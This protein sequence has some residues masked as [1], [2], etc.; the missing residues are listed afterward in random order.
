MSRNQAMLL[1]AIATAVSAA[2]LLLATPG[3]VWLRVAVGIP[4]VLL[5]PGQALMLFVD[6]DGQLG[7]LE[8]FTL[9]V[10]A[11]I[12]LAI[13]IGMGLATSLGLTASGMIQT[14]T[15]FTVL[16]L[17]AARAHADFVPPR[18]LTVAKRNP[19]R[20]AALGALALLACAA[21]VLALSI[22]DTRTA[23]AD[24]TVQLWGLPDKSGGGLRIGA[25]NV[26][27]TSRR[28]RLT[29]Q[30]GGRLISQQEFTMPAGTDRQFTVLKSATWTNSA[31][32]VAVLTDMN[33][34]LSPRNIS[35]WTFE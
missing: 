25:N 26:N 10:S 19:A 14:L 6:P 30:Q 12:A 13:L 1:V 29:I 21:F 28:Y 16:C 15:F 31:P 27:A 9:S 8:W 5:L 23:Q 7:G 22:P 33:G 32:V 20:R 34:V 17:T 11:S 35:V 24:Q 2:I 4:F 3:L 18:R